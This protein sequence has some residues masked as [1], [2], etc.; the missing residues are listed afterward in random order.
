MKG[1]KLI[2]NIQ[3]N[4]ESIT[5][6]DF[7]KLKQDWL[8]LES[9]SAPLF[10][11]SW[12]WIGNWLKLLPDN[13]NDNDNLRLLSASHNNQL[14][15]LGIFIEHNITRNGCINSK[16]WLLHRTGNEE[17]DQI[18]IENNNFLIQEK[19]QKT[20]EQAIWRYLTKNQSQV[21]E[22]ILNVA[23]AADVTTISS[24]INQ[25]QLLSSNHERGYHIELSNYSSIDDYLISR[26][27]NTRQQIRR[28]HKLLTAAGEVKFNVLTDPQA[29]LKLL[30]QTKKWHIAKWK[31]TETP[32]G[33]TNHIFTDFHHTLIHTSHNNA[34]TLMSQL[35]LDDDILGCCY[36]FQ[37]GQTLYFY[38]SCIKPTNDNRIKRGLIMHFLMI[39]WL[40]THKRAISNYDFLA[41]D[42]R[43]KRSLANQT[44]SYTK[45]TFQKQKPLFAIESALKQL[46]QTLTR[47]FFRRT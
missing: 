24:S 44:D 29:Q 26:S 9:K 30:N 3:V 45:R 5:V 10:F 38:L 36:Y 21:D 35:T 6:N 37:H 47:L 14:V 8:A 46:K 23:K 31:N 32:S 33:F 18:W 22:F 17:L 15:A 13:D 25:Y 11:L 28:S 40:I 34:H 41:G 20:I 27:K 1:K 7:S 42:A 2:D 4:I 19:D 12:T 43:Y 16:Q 39:E